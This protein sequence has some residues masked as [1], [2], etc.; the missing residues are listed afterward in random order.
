MCPWSV[1]GDHRR[2]SMVDMGEA[3]RECEGEGWFARVDLCGGATAVLGRLK[4]DRAGWIVRQAE[5]RETGMCESCCGWPCCLLA[6]PDLNRRAGERVRVFAFCCPPFSVPHAAMD[7]HAVTKLAFATHGRGR[8]GRRPGGREGMSR[9]G[10]G[11]V[12][13]QFDRDGA[14]T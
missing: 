2:G 12:V 4:I 8:L 14:S 5:E 3:R 1:G 7:V 9:G 6:R 11:T 10:P 13:R